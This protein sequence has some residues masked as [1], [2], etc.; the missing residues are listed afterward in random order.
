MRGD[1]RWGWST[2]VFL[3]GLASLVWAFTMASCGGGGGGDSWAQAPATPSF[4]MHVSSGA[5]LT[6]PTTG[7]NE[8]RVV[9]FTPLASH[10]VPIYVIV[11][12]TYTTTS[13][14]VLPTIRIQTLDANGVLL[15][16]SQAGT[17]GYLSIGA[18]TGVPFRLVMTMAGSMSGTSALFP[19]TK[20]TFKI[21]TA[22]WAG[23]ISDCKVRVVSLDN[24]PVEDNSPLIAG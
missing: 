1:A 14:A 24:N 8:V 10:D 12:G 4:K 17:P 11:E 23:S 7:V 19:G 22:S 15:I 16:D 20:Y 3:L 6:V 21:L 13:T 5:T 2:G 9:D 18:G